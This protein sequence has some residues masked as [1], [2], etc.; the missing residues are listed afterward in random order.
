M[1]GCS[2]PDWTL[3]RTSWTRTPCL[4]SLSASTSIDIR[5]A[6][7]LEG[8]VLHTNTMLAPPQKTLGQLLSFT[9]CNAC[10]APGHWT[11]NLSHCPSPRR[12]RRNSVKQK[13]HKNIL[14]EQ[15]SCAIGTT[16]GCWPNTASLTRGSWMMFPVC[17]MLQNIAC[18]KAWIRSVPWEISFC[19]LCADAI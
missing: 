9:C 2:D 14:K 10:K 15:V 18:R 4:V 8:D 16:R 1:R 3:L 13:Q 5:M 7:P 6:I 11:W 19:E 17:N 12:K